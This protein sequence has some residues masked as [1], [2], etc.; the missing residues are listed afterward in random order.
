MTHDGHGA[1]DHGRPVGH[2]DLRAALAEFATGVVLLTVRD[3]RDDIGATVSAFCPVS[4]EPPLVLVA[5]MSGS[6]LAEVLGRQ[7]TF[8]V[9]ILGEGQRMLA[10]RFAAAGRPSARR[11]LDEVPHT[12]GSRSGA[13]IA[14]SGLGAIEC[15]ARQRVT[16]GDHLLVV[17]EAVN[18]P[19]AGDGAAPLIRFRGGYPALVPPRP[20]P[21]R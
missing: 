20:G 1:H 11:L 15:A 9:T 13:L 8:A 12:R 6:Y 2:D 17:A 4:L 14:D 10:G 7:D 19:Y 5:I 16:A 18:V 3:G 21:P